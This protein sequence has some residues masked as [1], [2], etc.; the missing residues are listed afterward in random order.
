MARILTKLRIDE[1]SAVDAGAGDGVKIVLMKRDSDRPRS[2]PHLERYLRRLRKFENIFLKQRDDQEVSTTG[3]VYPRSRSDVIGDDRDRD[4][5]ED[6]LMTDNIGKAHRDRGAGPHGLTG[7][8]LEHLH[9]RLERR[10]EQHGYQ[11]SAKEEPMDTVH[12]IMK[13]GGIAGVCAQIVAKGSTTVSEHELVDAASKVAHERYPELSSAQAFAKIYSDGGEEGRVLRQAVNVA[14]ASLAETMLGPGLPVQVVGGPRAMLDA[15]NND[16][17]DV[18]QARAE[19][20]R[21]GRKQ[22][23]RSSENEIFERA[24][25]DPRNATTVARLY[26]RPT[27]SS[28][29]PMPREWLRGDGS[30]HAKAD[31]SNS[32]ATAYAELMLKA[33][34]YRNAHPELSVAQCFEKIYTDRANVELAKRERVES[35]PR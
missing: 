31:R 11:K 33:E 7:A 15:A 14:K 34:A 10:R 28:I 26:Q 12:S 17:S 30:Q 19:L 35:A 9:D 3:A 8:L 27:P 1:V 13:D 5:E 32:E 22:Y 23:P 21:I 20:M 4:D 18:E 6:D 2:K 16:Q 24:F 29:Y 25:S